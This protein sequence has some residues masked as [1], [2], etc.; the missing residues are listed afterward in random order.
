MWGQLLK[1][2]FPRLASHRALA[3]DTGGSTRLPAAYCG[4]LGFKPS[5]GLFLLLY[6]AKTA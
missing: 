2:S 6:L 4:V 5:Y 1:S 3:S